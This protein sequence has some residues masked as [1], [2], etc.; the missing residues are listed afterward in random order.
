MKII[1]GVDEVGRGPLAGPVCVGVAAV[2]SNFNWED[3]P[4]VNDSK[5]LTAAKRSSIYE[6]AVR[7]KEQ[8]HI[9][10]ATACLAANVIDERGIVPAIKAATATALTEVKA[11]SGMAS[12][13]WYTQVAVKLDGGLKAPV[14]Y[15]HQETIIKGDS[16]ER[17]IG[18]ASIVAKVTRDRL[19]EALSVLPEFSQYGFAT[20]KGYGTKKHREIIAALGLTTEHRASFCRRIAGQNKEDN[21]AS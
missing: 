18:L 13:D 20:H 17:V 2:P 8:G 5:K 14:E 16:K 19:M 15:Q 21:T 1:L 7:L 3:L 12:N 6:A 10:F 11:R 4:G 9:D